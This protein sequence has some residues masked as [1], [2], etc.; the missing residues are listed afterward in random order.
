MLTGS[1]HNLS[2]DRV[3]IGQSHLRHTSLA[4]WTRHTL[5]GFHGHDWLLDID[6][7]RIRLRCVSCG[8]ATRGWQIGRAVH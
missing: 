3:R 7:M 4:S 5:C 1:L 2:I 6:R 8:Y